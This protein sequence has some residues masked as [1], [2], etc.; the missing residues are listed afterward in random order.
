LL[1]DLPPV[2][3][4]PGRQDDGIALELLPFELRRPPLARRAA[5]FRQV[6]HRGPSWTSKK[7]CLSVRRGLASPRAV[8]PHHSRHR[9][10]DRLNIF[11]DHDRNARLSTF[12]ARGNSRS[13]AR[14]NLLRNNTL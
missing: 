8:L 3:D 2:D 6:V 5:S 9:V 12:E 1:L 10:S 14:R 4:L 7:S 11:Q 13:L